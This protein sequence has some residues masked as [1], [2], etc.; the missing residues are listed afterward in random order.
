LRRVAAA[1]R[2]LEAQA[3]RRRRDELGRA[4]RAR[5]AQR[6]R[7][8]LDPVAVGERDLQPRRRRLDDAQ[9]DRARPARQQRIDAQL[10]VVADRRLEQARVDASPRDVLEHLLRA[11]LLDRHCGAQL[12]VDVEGESAHD[13]A[14]RERELEL[15]FEDAR[16][17][18][19]EDHLHARLRGAAADLDV[20]LQR[21]EPDRLLRP[22]HL[23]HRRSPDRWRDRRRDGLRDGRRWLRERERRACAGEGECRDGECRARGTADGDGGGRSG[24][25]A[26][27]LA[28]ATRPV[29]VWNV[30]RAPMG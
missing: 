12:A 4:R 3:E 13:L 18:I 15:A 10:V 23:Q 8:V 1:G 7:D 28:A 16:V 2:A 20:E 26:S 6:D 22:L 19:E 14:G 5:N 29:W 24:R 21:R 30:P 9:L 25:H 11:R 17:R 27:S